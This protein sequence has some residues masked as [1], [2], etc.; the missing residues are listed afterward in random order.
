MALRLES[1]SITDFR[2]IKGTITLPLNAPV[3]LIHGANGTGKTSV[4]SALEIALTGEVVAFRRSDP[5]YFLHLPHRDAAEARIALTVSGEPTVSPSPAVNMTVTRRG[6][7]NRP[8]FDVS[9]ARFF[10]ERCYLAQSTLGRLLEIYQ[11]ADATDRESPLTRFVKDVLGLDLL[12]AVIQGLHAADDIRRVRKLVSAFRDTED[13]RTGANKRVSE[14]ASSARTIEDQIRASRASVSELLPQIP[15]FSGRD[16]S[17]ITPAEIEAFLAGDPEERDLIA[18]ASVRRT[19]ASLRSDWNSVSAGPEAEQ[20]SLAEGQERS[21]RAALETWRHQAGHRLEA[22][23]EGLRSIFPDLPSLAS[24]DPQTAIKAAEERINGELNRC[25]NVLSQD[26]LAAT[27]LLAIEEA[28]E[29]GRA[30]IAVT[31]GQISELA[32]DAAGLS[33]ALAA[34]VPHVHTEECPVCGRDYSE[35]S[36]EPLL[37]RLSS[38]VSELTE[39]GGRLQALAKA[40][41]E[42]VGAVTASERERDS[43]LQRRVSQETR[44]GLK[45]RA[46]ELLESRRKLDA[47]KGLA[48]NGAVVLRTDAQ[49]RGQLAQ[50]RQ[51]DQRATDVRLAVQRLFTESGQAFGEN[52]I[53]PEALNRLETH[54]QSRETQLLEMQAKRQRALSEHRNVLQREGE[55]RSVRAEI[56]QQQSML[57]RLNKAFERAE[58]RRHEARRIGAAARKAR[59]TIVS[60]VFNDSLNA[61]WRDLFV[62]LAPTEP[63]VP[64]FRLP[65][66]PESPIVAA[67]ETIHRGGGRG[68]TPGAMLSAGNLNTAALTLFLALHLSV[69]VKLPWLLLDDPVQSM[70]EVHVSQFAALLRTLSKSHNRQIIIAVHDRA[71]FEY[72]TLEL[73]PAFPDDQLITLELGRS[74][75]GAS[76]AEPVFRR[77]EPE[78]LF[79]AG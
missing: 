7:Q 9:R 28:I 43:V 25:N 33:Q 37:V 6:P 52:E 2:S 18:L 12:D 69:S 36:K 68:G 23:I 11:H 34:L 10:A 1:I 40:R 64:A 71:L 22:I 21:A 35:V 76:L 44:V 24:T 32:G 8:L 15:E 3:V 58:E 31:D 41:S 63:F 46:A 49:A 73:S 57:D 30:R 65:E 60:R 78:K 67:L 45:A 72:L 77:W 14:L 17:A 53:V 42:T 66:T 16:V 29:R 75:S 79:A 38:R 39:K 62:R 4:L 48:A 27:Q 59:S 74:D 13:A 20:R 55:L 26:D 61:V 47:V 50:L 54:L 70:D 51:R 19:V 5:N 56:D